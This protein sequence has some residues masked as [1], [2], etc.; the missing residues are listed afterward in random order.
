MDMYGVLG[1]MCYESAIC[2]AA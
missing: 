2:F 1:F